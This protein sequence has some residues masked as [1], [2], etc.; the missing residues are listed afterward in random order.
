MY[1]LFLIIAIICEVVA[2]SALKACDGFTKLCPSII[3]IVGYALT[4]YFFSICIRH[5]NLGI[6]YAI[7]AGVGIV[8]IAISSVVIFKQLMDIPAIIGI[9]FIM[10]GVL[11]INLFSKTVID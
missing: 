11:V 5:I 6:A 4:L 1:F 10:A 3:V 9:V 8:L 2:T 7:W